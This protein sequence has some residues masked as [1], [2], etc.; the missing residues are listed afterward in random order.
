MAEACQPG[1]CGK[2]DDTCG[3]TI[4]C[5]PCPCAMCGAGCCDDGTAN[6]NPFEAM[7]CVREPNRDGNC[8]P[9][10]CYYYFTGCTNVPPTCLV[11]GQVSG[12]GLPLD[13]CCQTP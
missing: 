9:S 5:G 7:G 2:V 4:D 10:E 1:V 3:G 11:V 8:V 12:P 13:V 6:C